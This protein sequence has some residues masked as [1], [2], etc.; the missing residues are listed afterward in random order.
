MGSSLLGLGNK[1]A[2]F[3]P[4]A[5][6]FFRDMDKKVKKLQTADTKGELYFEHRIM[7][8]DIVTT[9]YNFTW[10]PKRHIQKKEKRVRI[11]TNIKIKPLILI[12]TM[13]GCYR[14]ENSAF[15]GKGKLAQ[16]CVS[17]VTK[18]QN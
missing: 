10:P 3:T 11:Y 14:W 2:W 7:D 16:G 18:L 6:H 4:D 9:C 8:L 17:L 12:I 5:L 15:T 1:Q 13:Q